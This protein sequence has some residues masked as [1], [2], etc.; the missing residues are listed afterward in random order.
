MKRECC[1]PRAKPG[2]WALIEILVVVA[3][4][5]VAFSFYWGLSRSGNSAAEREL[6][7]PTGTTVATNLQDQLQNGTSGPNAAPAYGRPANPQDARPGPDGRPVEPDNPNTSTTN[8][9]PPTTHVRQPASV[10]GRA[11]YKAQGERCQS[12][13]GQLRLAIQMATDDRGGIFPGS[14][15]DVPESIKMRAC[16]VGGQDYAYDPNTGKVWC[17]TPGHENF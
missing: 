6:M 13:I 4:I 14:L 5:L 2:F 10:P 9:P 17:T 3:I 15:T 12:N 1:H 11:V 7:D 16:P 8:Q